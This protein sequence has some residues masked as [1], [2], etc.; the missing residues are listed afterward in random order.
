M[1]HLQIKIIKCR[2]FNI[3]GDFHVPLM[4]MFL[5]LAGLLV[6]GFCFRRGSVPSVSYHTNVYVLNTYYAIA[7]FWKEIFTVSEARRWLNRSTSL[8]QSQNSPLILPG[9]VHTFGSENGRENLDN[10]KKVSRLNSLNFSLKEVKTVPEL[11][12]KHVLKSFLELGPK[13]ERQ[14]IWWWMIWHFLIPSRN[15]LWLKSFCQP[16]FQ[17]L[18]FGCER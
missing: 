11:A 2:P 13:L 1:A 12:V 18:S 4:H 7:F 16:E 14:V 10:G 15:S 6:H 17:K 3:P 5:V 8:S 9:V